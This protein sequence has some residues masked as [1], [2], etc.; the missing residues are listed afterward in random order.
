MKNTAFLLADPRKLTPEERAARD[1]YRS[2][3]GRTAS[4]INFRDIPSLLDRT[5]PAVL[6]WHF[7]AS[8]DLPPLT[9][10]PEVIA[11]LRSYVEQGGGL[12]L[13]LLAA[14]FVT[15]LGFEA[16]PPNVIVKGSWE[17]RCWAPGTQDIR[18]IASVRGHPLF[19]GLGNGVYTWSPAPGDPF[20]AA[21]YDQQALPASGL[22]VGVERQ[23][24]RI[25]D[26]RRIAVEYPRGKGLI[27]TIGSFFF[28]AHPH[29]RF[30]QHLE[31]LAANGFAY[32]S[33]RARPRRGSHW[34]YVQRPPEESS[35]HSRPVQTGEGPLP[36]GFLA[37]G[38]TRR[39]SMAND[40]DVGGRRILILG[41]ERRGIEEVWVHPFRIL[42]DLRLSFTVG[43]S[44][45]Q[46]AETLVEEV[47]IRPGVIVRSHR[48]NGALI[49][50]SVFGDRD[51][52]TGVARYRIES[53]LPVTM[54][55]SARVDLRAMWP[56][57]AAA[58]GT[59]RYGWDDGLQALRVTDAAGIGVSLIGCGR[60][61]DSRRIEAVGGE[62]GEILLELEY[63]LRPGDPPLTL[64]FAGSGEREA[65]AAYRRMLKAPGRRL[66]IQMRHYRKILETAAVIEGPD[67]QFN[68]AY[69]A[70]L[71]STER[72]SAEIP[73]LG[74]SVMA[75]YA[76]TA[77]GWDGGQAGKSVV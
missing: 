31:R 6:W 57:T 64:A 34:S 65:M 25:D 37:P 71:V 24:I 59:L 41:D 4:V 21:W 75:G 9:R 53:T 1:F 32:I 73:G 33:S 2:R 72:F 46:R 18:G 7:D 42:N 60:R 11:A 49:E 3:F 56:L 30:R 68:E 13:S 45:H 70:A 14:Q 67:V 36:T 74:S 10:H 20:A 62:H 28:F 63:T 51:L 61:P 39:P 76:S 50:E 38:I 23:Y 5:P 8:T 77:H 48:Y 54:A 47:T 40:F 66:D 35:R 27:L 69:R 58:T 15:E 17:E 26:S 16:T 29:P 55:V 52:P 44:E 22:V 43:G 19:D 12:L